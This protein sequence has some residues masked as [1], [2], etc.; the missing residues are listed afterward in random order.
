MELIT[1]IPGHATDQHTLSD[2]LHKGG[3]EGR[4]K[5][6]V[7]PVKLEACFAFHPFR[8]WGHLPMGFRLMLSLKMHVMYF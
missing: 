7:K 2:P 3:V 5:W 6:L 4:R 8:G 1:L